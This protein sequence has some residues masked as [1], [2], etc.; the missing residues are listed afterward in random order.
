MAQGQKSCKGCEQR[1][2]G[3]FGCIYWVR[4]QGGYCYYERGYQGEEPYED[5]DEEA[6]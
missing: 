3:D 2:E 1:V 6:A 4:E 5:F